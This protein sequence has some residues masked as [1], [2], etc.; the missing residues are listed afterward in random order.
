MTGIMLIVVC[1]LLWGVWGFASKMSNMHNA[2]VFVTLA[3]NVL[4][5]IFSLPLFYKLKQSG[6]AIN[7]GWMAV[8]WIALT[9][10]VGVGAKLLF[11]TALSKAPVSQVIAATAIYPVVTA[12]LAICFLKE[13]VTLTQGV[14]MLLCVIGVYLVI[15]VK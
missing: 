15:A 7:W 3:T 13:R 4:Y 9:S 8:F 12:L 2:P 14:G 1:I 10:V 6:E 11:N 5:A